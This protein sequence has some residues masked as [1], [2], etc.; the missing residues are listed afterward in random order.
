MLASHVAI[1]QR[2][3]PIKDDKENDLSSWL[4]MPSCSRRVA[5]EL[6]TVQPT[7]TLSKEVTFLISVVSVMIVR[8]QVCCESD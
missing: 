4:F 8:Q 3:S 6:V 2:Q 7:V 5:S 1:R